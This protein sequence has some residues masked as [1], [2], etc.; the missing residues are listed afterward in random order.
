MPGPQGLHT[1][2]HLVLVTTP[3]GMRYCFQFINYRIGISRG[4]CTQLVRGQGW[5][6]N[7]WPNFRPHVIFNKSL[8][9]LNLTLT[10]DLDKSI[11]KVKSES[12][13]SSVLSKSLWPHGPYCPWNTPDQNIG[14][15]SYSLLQGIFL[16]QW[17]NQGLLNC[18]QI[19]H[20]LSHEGSSFDI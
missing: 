14:V 16:T 10:N 15:G 13:S 18:R 4:I 1:L 17:S 6:F 11:P 7:L 5:D 2:F 12:V 3:G 9:N 20:C 19:L 8:Y